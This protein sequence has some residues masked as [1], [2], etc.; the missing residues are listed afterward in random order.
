MQDY[1]YTYSG[2]LRTLKYFYEVK[3]GDWEKGHGIRLV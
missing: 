3:H 1:D 2:I